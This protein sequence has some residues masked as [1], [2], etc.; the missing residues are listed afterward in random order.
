[1]SNLY[2][3]VVCSYI[4]FT[5]INTKSIKGASRRLLFLVIFFS[6]I[7]A[8]A[9]HAFAQI[10]EQSFASKIQSSSI[11][12]EAKVVQKQTYW[13]DVNSHI[14]TANE[15]EIYKVFKGQIPSGKHYVITQ[16][17][18]VGND[19]LEVCP[20]LQLG[21]GEIGVFML[22]N[23]TAQISV[24]NGL[25]LAPIAEQQAFYSYDNFSG[26]ASSPFDYNQTVAQLHTSI[27][28][29]TNQVITEN[30][31]YT[32]EI[33]QFPESALPPQITSISPT[34][35][36]GGVGDILTITGT[37]FGV[38]LPTS[39]VMFYDAD[40]GPGVFW[41]DVTTVITWTDTLIR[42]IV[43]VIFFPV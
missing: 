19:R 9:K 7:I 5:E 33:I 41:E 28:I 42:L 38:Q 24:V 36:N 14:F 29:Q 1:M 43:P 40:V 4:F 39:K 34:T 21:V 25:K 17:G 10:L 12:V 20:S 37:G 8:P 35:L 15:I 31:P 13:N 26:K 16:G 3:S 30:I 2:K 23:S 27:Q 6:L 11:I 32:F 18:T 22:E